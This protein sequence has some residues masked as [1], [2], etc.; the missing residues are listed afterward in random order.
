M[1][2]CPLEGTKHYDACSLTNTAHE[3]PY[4]DTCAEML[5]DEKN[6]EDTVKVV[7]ELLKKQ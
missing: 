4:K 2:Q 1:S 5:Q 7:S 6:A 3:C